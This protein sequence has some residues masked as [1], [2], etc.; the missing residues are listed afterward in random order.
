MVRL[1]A[2][3]GKHAG[4]AASIW[5]ARLRL[6]NVEIRRL[7][8]LEAAIG[9]KEASALVL[10]YRFGDEAPPALILRAARDIDPVDQLSARLELARKPAPAF[11]LSGTDIV[12]A[13][14]AAGPKVGQ[15][16]AATE[17]RWIEAGLPSAVEAQQAILRQ[18]LA[19]A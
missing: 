1:A 5:Q 11:R 3:A 17:S 14:I 19:E 8:A 15:L 12:A 4:D 6:S 7:H 13:G 9:V 16:L 2:L 10:R 18:L